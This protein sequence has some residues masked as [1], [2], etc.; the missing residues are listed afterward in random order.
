MKTQLLVATN[1]GDYAEHLSNILSEYHCDVIDVTVC[2]SGE[3][4]QDQLKSRKYDV[5]LLEPT[6]IVEE[7]GL[8]SIRFPLVLW[9]ENEC[10]AE[11]SGGIGKIRKYQR[12]S[13][14]VGEVLELH[15]KG[16]KNGYG[17]CAKRAR[18]TAVWSPMGGVGKTTVALAYAERKALEGKQALYLDLQPFSSI[19]AYFAAAG[20][21]ISSAFEMI[22]TQ[23]GNI[24]MLLRSI[25]QQDNGSGVSYFC[26]PDNYDDMNILTPDGINLLLDACSELAEDLIVD[27][28]CLCDTCTQKVFELADRVFLVTDASRSSQIKFSQ[29][30]AQHNIFRHIKEKTTLVANRGAIVTDPLVDDVIS[31]PIVQSS[32]AIAVYKTLSGIIL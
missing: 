15:A 6:M 21:S 29:F 3:F 26:R 12:I 10:S 13:S 9:S 5:A 7:A 27:M 16:L 31:L 28:S 20:R 2:C 22:E 17:L 25:R 30:A 11:V 4:L 32:D 23:E 24:G 19:G 8:T 18:V 14:M 1:D